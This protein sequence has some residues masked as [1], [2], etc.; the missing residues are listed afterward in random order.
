MTRRE[1]LPEAARSV[2]D[3]NAY[4]VLGTADADGRPWTTPVYFGHERYAEFYWLSSPEARHSRN[5]AGR[6]EVSLVVFDSS[7][8]IGGA[9][10]VYMAATA[11]R[12]PDEEVPARAEVFRTPRFPGARFF[13][14]R[15]LL[16]GSLHLYRAVVEEHSILVRGSDPDLGRGVDSRYPVDVAD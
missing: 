10:A 14:P 5:I 6:P 13:E 8:P 1:D 2:V 7:A 3:G 15:E 9:Q 12:V 11:A 4:M 16:D